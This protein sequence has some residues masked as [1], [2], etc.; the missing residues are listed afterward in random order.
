MCVVCELVLTILNAEETTQLRR[1]ATWGKGAPTEPQTR[2]LCSIAEFSHTS[3]D[4]GH[5]SSSHI[6]PY[7]P[8][9]K[10]FFQNAETIISILLG[11]MSF[12]H[13]PL[14]RS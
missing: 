13:Q 5:V 10:L 12:I 14:T 4:V 3:Y 1:K 9:N 11:L 6:A 7:V 2:D 8:V